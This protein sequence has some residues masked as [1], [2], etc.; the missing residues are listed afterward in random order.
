MELVVSNSFCLIC[1]EFDDDMFFNSLYSVLK[2]LRSWNQVGT[3]MMLYKNNSSKSFVINYTDNNMWVISSL[4]FNSF[5]TEV[6]N[7][8]LNGE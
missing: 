8:L 7:E 5:E 1:E 4:G 6:F 3:T 2:F